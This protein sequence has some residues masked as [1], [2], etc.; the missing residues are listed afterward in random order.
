[1]FC[2]LPTSRPIPSCNSQL[3]D[4]ECPRDI[5]APARA[6]LARATERGRE[7]FVPPASCR[8][9]FP[10]PNFI[11]HSRIFR[12]P[13][14]RLSPRRLPRLINRPRRRCRRRSASHP[15]LRRG[16]PLR[17]RRFARLS[18]RHFV[19]SRRRIRS[20]RLLQH[21]RRHVPRD[22]HHDG[23]DHRRHRRGL[24]ASILDRHHLRPRAALLRV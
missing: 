8:Q 6:M 20:R 10:E 16:H 9:V 3:S 14:A 12:A 22:R 5:R 21:S 13:L 7:G 15:R 2:R 17:H 23:R 24:F 1:M 18:D 4:V 19:R 11:E